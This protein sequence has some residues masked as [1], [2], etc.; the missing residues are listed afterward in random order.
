MFAGVRWTGISFNGMNEKMEKT[1]HDV[2]HGSF[3]GL[4][5]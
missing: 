1:N 3:C 2:H 4:T 5:G